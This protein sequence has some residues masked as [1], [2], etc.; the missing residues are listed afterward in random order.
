MNI[1]G[2]DR[3]IEPNLLVD[4]ERYAI[5]LATSGGEIL[6]SHFGTDLDVSYKDVGKSDPVTSVDIQ[7]QELLAKQISEKFP[8]HGIVGEE[9]VE[10][11]GD[12]SPDVIWVIDP[13]D[14]TKNFVG[15]LPIFAC[16]I[17]ILYRGEPVAGAIY[18]PWP[19]NRDGVIAHARRGGG[20][21]IGEERLVVSRS[22]ESSGNRLVG[23]PGSFSSRFQ[24][25]K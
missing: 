13:L 11:D 7:I 21:F 4:I 18:I 10:T 12:L 25:G 20:A 22:D 16:S 8:D 24:F 5:E 9:G 3:E 14:G 15:G 6:S 2:T 17:G 1:Y 19:G 23:L